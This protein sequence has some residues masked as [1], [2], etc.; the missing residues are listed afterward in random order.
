[1]VHNQATHLGKRFASPDDAN[2]KDYW[3][4]RKRIKSKELTPSRQKIAARQGFNCPVCG[5]SLFN[6]EIL[7]T[8]HIKPRSKG[9][10]DNYANLQLVHLYC[11]QQ[12]HAQG[13]AETIE[14]EQEE[15][16]SVAL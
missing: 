4:E 12:L 1:M 6:E 2:L 11:H 5:E 10:K 14:L 9:G 13:K 15:E 3:E 8:H 16:D 7:H